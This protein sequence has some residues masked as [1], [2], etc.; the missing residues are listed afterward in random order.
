MRGKRGLELAVG[1]RVA[2]LADGGLV[3]EDVAGDAGAAAAG[4]GTLLEGGPALVPVALKTLVEV[5]VLVDVRLVL[6]DALHAHEQAVLAVA[7]DVLHPAV[8][9]RARCLLYT[10]P[11][12]RD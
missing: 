12:P 11:S 3:T 7:E 5:A 2:V 4:A 9:A 10:S 6:H 8:H 1:K